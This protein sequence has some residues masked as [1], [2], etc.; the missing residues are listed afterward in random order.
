MRFVL[1]SIFR[2]AGN[3]LKTSWEKVRKFASSVIPQV[4]SGENSVY[5]DLNA[6]FP[7]LYK[8]KILVLPYNTLESFTISLLLANGLVY[9]IDF[10]HRSGEFC[11][12]KYLRK[13][14]TQSNCI[15]RFNCARS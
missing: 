7:C 10:T 2:S 9:V 12:P 15:L 13:L 11:M 5:V 14:I 3:F 6:T 4:G 8:T 1:P